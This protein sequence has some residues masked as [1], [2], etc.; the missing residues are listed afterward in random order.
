MVNKIYKYHYIYKTTNLINQKYY[1]GMHS[2]DNLE[3][4]YKGSGKILRASIKKYGKEN[5]KFEILEYLDDRKTLKEREKEIV[6]K[7][8]ID[9]K[10]CMNLQLGGGG[11][12]AGE[13]HE[14]KFREGASKSL[15]ERWENEEYKKQMKKRLAEYTRAN[16]L[17]KKIKQPNWKGKKHK[18]ETKERLKFLKKGTGMGFTNSQANTIW[19]TNGIINK[20]IKKEETL[21]EGFYKGRIQNSYRSV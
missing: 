6:N 4:G 14:R 20:K 7:E 15:K 1:I 10:F 17:A 9:N 18:E 11:G 13:E 2:T 8:E 12:F 3:D 5:F 19:I 21:P 16:H